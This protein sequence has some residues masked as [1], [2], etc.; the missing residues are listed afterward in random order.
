MR[1]KSIAIIV[2]LILLLIFAL[3]KTQPVFLSFLLWQ[4]SLS[5]VLSIL[6][7]FITGLLIVYLL[8]M[9]ARM[10]KKNPLLDY[11]RSNLFQF[12]LARYLEKVLIGNR[13]SSKKKDNLLE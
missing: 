12:L 3:Q 9:V 4:I 11:S 6:V 5:S 7:S 13:K 1:A 8:M 10:K 2:L